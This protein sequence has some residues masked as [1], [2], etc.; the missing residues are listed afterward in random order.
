L[1]KNLINLFIFLIST[2]TQASWLC[3]EA[4]SFQ[5]DN[6]FYACGHATE[7]TLSKAR[8]SS[9][10]AAKREFDFFCSESHFCKTKAFNIKPMRTDCTKDNKGFSCYRG[11]EFTILK[12]ERVIFVNKD[13]FK[14]KEKTLERKL[15]KL[16]TIVDSNNAKDPA[17]DENQQKDLDKY[18][19]ELAD[20]KSKKFYRIKNVAKPSAFSMVLGTTGVTFKGDEQPLSETK[21]LT[22]FGVEYNGKV[23]N[24]ISLRSQFLIHDSFDSDEEK[25]KKTY[26]KDI[27]HSY[28]ALDLNIG[29]SILT[30][31][32]FIIPH[33][34][35]ISSS[36]SYTRNDIVH[37]SGV[38][39][40]EAEYKQSSTYAGVGWRYGERYFIEVSPRYY[41]GHK[42]FSGSV[43]IGLNFGY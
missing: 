29:I 30:N 10:M 23:W 19:I 17:I 39:T 12:Q 22:T 40:K 1:R 37:P 4:S 13:E 38:V 3:K 21:F 31:Y 33:F 6:I 8:E 34:G 5:Q 26:N 16:Y 18:E 35:T 25:I 42:E 2:K 28:N 43:S 27:Y 9:L 20:I 41:L 24:G 36:Y 32:G 7:S 14:E 11:L 15:D